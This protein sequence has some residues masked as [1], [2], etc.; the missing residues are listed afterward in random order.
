MNSESKKLKRGLKDL[1]HLFQKGRLASE[2]PLW[3]PAPS[4]SLP[5]P[6]KTPLS[7]SLPE[8]GIQIMSVFC[9]DMASDA[10]LVE[11]EQFFSRR[12]PPDEK[13]ETQE[14]NY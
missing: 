14:S 11:S 12:C 8:S 1:S 13:E 4:E 6:V 10:T 7:E 5:Q 9:L 2:Q 3:V